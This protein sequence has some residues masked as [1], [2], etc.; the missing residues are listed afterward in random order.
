M[1]HPRHAFM[2]NLESRLRDAFLE[3]D[4]NADIA[5]QFISDWKKSNPPM[6]EIEVSIP[7]LEN[8]LFKIPVASWRER[9]AIHARIISQKLEKGY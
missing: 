2:G 6:E 3:H 8:A 1:K 7:E 9:A 5:E 4:I